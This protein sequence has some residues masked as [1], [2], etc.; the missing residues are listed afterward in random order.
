MPVDS[1][2]CS[3]C[4]RTD[5]D[6]VDELLTHDCEN[7]PDDDPS[8]GAAPTLVADGG[9]PTG[10]RECPECGLITN[11]LDLTITS[12]G[13]LVCPGCGHI[14]TSYGVLQR[15]EDHILTP[16]HQQRSGHV[17]HKPSND[18]PLVPACDEKVRQRSNDYYRPISASQL[19]DDR[20]ELCKFCDPDYEIDRS[21]SSRGHYNSL[22]AAAEDDGDLIADGGVVSEDAGYQTHDGN[23]VWHV[24]L[25]V[26]DAGDEGYRVSE[27]GV[28]IIET[29]DTVGEAVAAYAHAA[30]DSE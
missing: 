10:D 9:H 26:E 12:D 29:G 23:D 18:H 21:G 28:S 11:R 25:R 13:Q 5:F 16:I 30:C 19:E 3:D 22:K 4:G 20:I 8:G 14:I 6:N 17:A 15:D 1:L 2:K 24:T 27:P 7:R